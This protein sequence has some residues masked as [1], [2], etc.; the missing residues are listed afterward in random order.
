MWWCGGG[1]GG[2]VGAGSRLP[3]PSKSMNWG[4]SEA[5]HAEEKDHNR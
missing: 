1:G 3:H 2:G 4:G 5:R